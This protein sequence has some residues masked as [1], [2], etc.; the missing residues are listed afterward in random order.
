MMRH[1]WFKYV[2]SAIFLLLVGELMAQPAPPP[3]LYAFP[4][5]EALWTESDGTKY[6]MHGDTVISG[7]TYQKIYTSTDVVFDINNATYFGAIV[8]DPAGV[9]KGRLVGKPLPVTLYDYKAITGAF[10][11]IYSPDYGVVNVRVVGYDSIQ[12]VLDT[13]PVYKMETDQGY[14]FDWISGVGS[15][16]GLFSQAADAN[17]SEELYCFQ[18]N[19]TLIYLHP[20]SVD[21]S[22]VGVSE[23]LTKHVNVYPNPSMG[24]FFVEV[25]HRI[26]N[27]TLEIVDSQGSLIQLLNLGSGNRF[28]VDDLAIA[29]GLYFYHLRDKHSSKYSGKLIFH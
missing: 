1:L 16:H 29:P 22:I 27:A 20:S 15:K 26:E 10:V 2:V 9:I 17:I 5:G 11:P 7:I 21:C 12:A 18:K 4:T 6:A 14:Q 13:R 23:V 24:E 25:D 28:T 3:N 8:E 19:D